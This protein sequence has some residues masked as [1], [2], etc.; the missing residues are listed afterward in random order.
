MRALYAFLIA[1]A[2][3]WAMPRDAGAQILYVTNRP[4]GGAVVV[5]EYNAATGE[6]INANFIT[7]LSSENDEGL[8]LLRNTLFVANSNNGTVGA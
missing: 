3:L 7:G 5:S 1:F 8:A 6:L 2:T 4:G